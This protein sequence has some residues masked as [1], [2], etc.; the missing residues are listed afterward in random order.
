MQNW[1]QVFQETIDEFESPYV[2]GDQGDAGKG[3]V[4]VRAGYRINTTLDP[5]VGYISKNPGQAQ[6]YGVATDALTDCIDGSGA[7]FL[8]DELQGDG[9]RLIRVA[10]TPYATPPPGSPPPT[11]WVQPTADYLTYPGPLV[12]KATTPPPQPEPEPEPP[13]S[14]ATARFDA[15][16]AAHAEIIANANANT[17]KI[18]QQIHGLVEDAE[19]TLI[20]I[21][22]V[23][24]LFWR[25]RPPR[26]KSG[27]Q[28][29]DELDAWLVTKARVIAAD[30]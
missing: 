23:L 24:L 28:A 16:D 2:P 27:A 6:F 30:E 9:R 11:N 15:L 18:Q 19:A 10:Y 4:L 14:D 29:V 3:Q 25:E 20:L 1:S 7:D 17:E 5:R 8:T 13:P 12:L 26:T 22:K 21:A